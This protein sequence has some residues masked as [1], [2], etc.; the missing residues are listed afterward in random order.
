[1][2]KKINVNLFT[3]YAGDAQYSMLS[4]ATQLKKSLGSYFINNCQTAVFT[5]TET[6][7]SKIIRNNFIGKKADSYW[8]R[9]VS[10][11]AIARKICDGVNH[12][13]D[14]NNSYLIRYLDPMRT[15]ITCH[16]L[17][18]FRIQDRKI[19]KEFLSPRHAIR[20]YTVS[21][22][23]KA[24]RIIS[25]SENSKKDLMELFD[26]P[27]DKIVVIYPGIRPCFNKIEDSNVLDE[28][29]KKLG[30]NWSNT[31]LHVGENLY[32]KNI[33]SIFHTL[34]ILL[35]WGVE[36]IHFVKV[37]KDFS[38]EQKNLILKLGIDKY[39]HN[40]GNLDDDDLVLVYNLSDVLVFPSLYEGFGWPPLEAMACG[41]PVVCS[42]KGSLNE[43][44][45]DSAIFIEPHDHEGIAKAI[46]TLIFDPEIR[47]DRIRQGFENVKRF[48]WK[49]TAEAVFQTYREVEKKCAE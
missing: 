19:N 28:G 36:N 33:E 25:D 5:P 30:F 7:F 2:Y 6:T 44:V 27:P 47:Q 20:K 24:A 48:D 45:G 4:Y 15:V 46:L 18:Y 43:I 49:K 32:Y 1:V 35:K 14:H 42:N 29:R 40:I 12:I 13:I 39:V 26:V 41:T 10:H 38:L 3:N 34:K 8:R 21:G 22:I 23:K 31:I 16:D 9:F 37:G 17:I 11:P